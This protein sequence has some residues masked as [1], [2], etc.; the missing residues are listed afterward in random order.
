MKLHHHACL[1]IAGVGLLTGIAPAF[2]QPVSP[3]I[4]VSWNMEWLAEQAAMKKGDF[5][6]KCK[7]KA[8][9]NELAASG[10]PPCSAVAAYGRTAAAYETKKLAPLR[11]HLARLADEGM[12][13]LA[14][15]EVGSPAAL[16]A[17]LPQNWRVAC[18]TKTSQAQNIGYAVRANAAF[19]WQCRQ[20]DE[21]SLPASTGALGKYRPGLEFAAQVGGQSGLKLTLLNIHLKASC[22]TRDM[23]SQDHKNALDCATLQRQVPVLE[24]WMEHQAQSGAAF[25]IVGD[26]NRDLSREIAHGRPARTDGS[27]PSTS[28]VVRR[29][30][31]LW[32][33][34]N[35]YTPAGSSMG[36]AQVDRQPALAAGCHANLDQAAASQGLIDTLHSS[37]LV[38]KRLGATLLSAP[39]VSDH[40]PMRIELR[41]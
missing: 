23:S 22:S 6:A 21:L 34:I 37:S 2:S 33:E 36:L 1:L 16:E 18:F 4:V 12:D 9:A 38:G 10:L 13:V 17:V 7:A 31:Y 28:P 25:M 35:D 41:W 14:V 3:L 11:A 39:R 40:C 26:W 32:Q 19:Q 29:I 5:W 20:I 8:F 30:R 24:Q 27:D 15:Q